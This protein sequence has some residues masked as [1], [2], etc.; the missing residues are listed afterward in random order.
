MTTPNAIPRRT[1][2]HTSRRA[3][4]IASSRWP[5]PSRCATKVWP[6]ASRPSVAYAANNHTWNATAW[7]ADVPTPTRPAREAHLHVR[8]RVAR[9]RAVATEHRDQP[10]TGD[11]EDDD[12]GHA[13]GDGDPHGGDRLL[14]RLA[15]P[16]GA[17]ASGDGGGRPE[18]QERERRVPEH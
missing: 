5:A 13:E 12:R 4:V 3:I 2:H 15:F 11:C 16:A 9:D 6:A 8:P 14:V 1:A 10:P 7:A 18:H 17:V